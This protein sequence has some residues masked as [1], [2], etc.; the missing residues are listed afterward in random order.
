[1]KS[2]ITI[3]NAVDQQV[4]LEQDRNTSSFVVKQHDEQDN[5]RIITERAV[6]TLSPTQELYLGR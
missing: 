4:E 3:I 1:M 2:R 5:R 6:R